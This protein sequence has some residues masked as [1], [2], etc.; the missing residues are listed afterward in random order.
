[1][2]LCSW[3]QVRTMGRNLKNRINPQGHAMGMSLSYFFLQGYEKHVPVYFFMRL[4]IAST[5]VSTTDWSKGIV[6]RTS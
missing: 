6:S 4:L 2:I 1:M 5:V 3:I